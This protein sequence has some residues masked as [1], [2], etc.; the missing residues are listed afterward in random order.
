MLRLSDFM[1]SSSNDLID[2]SIGIRIPYFLYLLNCRRPLAFDTLHAILICNY[3]IINLINTKYYVSVYLR[4]HTRTHVLIVLGGGVLVFN[5]MNYHFCARELTQLKLKLFSSSKQ[6]I[7]NEI[8]L[9]PSF[10]LWTS[11][12]ENDCIGKT[13]PSSPPITVSYLD[14]QSTQHTST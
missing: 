8:I 11:W 7:L 13:S 10:I 1:A 12:D 6:K 4:S 3:F 2:S 9:F 5:V 14:P